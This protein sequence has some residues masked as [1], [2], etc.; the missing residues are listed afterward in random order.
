M[1]GV[2]APPAQTAL[3]SELE[4]DSSS[5]LSILASSFQGKSALNG[6]RNLHAT[7]VQAGSHTSLETGNAPASFPRPV[8]SFISSIRL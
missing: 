8:D 1:H 5:A 2:I 7:Q 6:E 4:N 3:I